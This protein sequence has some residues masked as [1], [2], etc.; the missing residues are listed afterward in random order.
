MDCRDWVFS[1]LKWKGE[2]DPWLTLIESS[3]MSIEESDPESSSS[4]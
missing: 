1:L 4:I 3:V 2:G